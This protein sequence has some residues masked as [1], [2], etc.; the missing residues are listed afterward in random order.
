LG[1]INLSYK[2]F[3]VYKV[4][5]VLANLSS[6]FFMK[7]VIVSIK[8]YFFPI[9][10]LGCNKEG[11]WVCDNC[12]VNIDTAGVWRCPVCNNFTFTGERCGRCEYKG[13]LMLVV[14]VSEYEEENLVGKLIKI[15]KYQYAE[16][17]VLVIEK[18]ISN[19]I[20]NHQDFFENIKTIVPVPLH[21]RRYAERGF[22][23]AELIAKALSKK[24]NIPMEKFLK[25]TRYTRQQVGLSREERQQNLQDAFV[26][27]GVV[28][29]PILL[30]DDVYTTGSTMQEC[31]K[32]LRQ[33]G[34]KEVG[35]F[36]VAR[37]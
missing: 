3:Q 24:I 33:A 11:E 36:V 31:A 28:C 30:V 34:V 37:G 21:S 15:I 35:G 6:P 16:E 20:K 10:C 8:D 13:Q 17:A 7:N 12:L 19:F 2:V 25:R 4:Y 9:Y 18:M 1:K 32:V 29:G 26:V 5:K 14:A 22:N 27:E 23:Q